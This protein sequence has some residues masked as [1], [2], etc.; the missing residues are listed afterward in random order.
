LTPQQKFIVE[1]AKAVATTTIAAHAADVDEKARFPQ[2]SMRALAEAGLWGVLVPAE[3]GGLGEGLRTLAAVTDEIAQHC[4]STAM[5]FMMHHC[6]V[7]CYLADPQK[8][9]AALRDAA[10]G[11][12]LST[13]A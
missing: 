12:H 8:F 6:G 13:L 4:A 9:G 3:F 7:N 10:A 5:V 11:N 2:E 1:K